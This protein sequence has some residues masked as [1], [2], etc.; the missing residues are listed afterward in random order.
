MAPAAAVP[1]VISLEGEA[2]LHPLTFKSYPAAGGLRLTY[3]APDPRDWDLGVLRARVGHREGKPNYQRMNTYRQWR[4]MLNQRCQN[5]GRS[6][7][8]PATGRVW[9]LLANESGDDAAEGWAS[10]PPICRACIPAA[11]AIC[12]HLR[13]H[14]ALYSVGGSEPFAVLAH[15]YRPGRDGRAVLDERNAMVRLDEFQRLT[16][17]L[18]LELRVLLWDAQRAPIP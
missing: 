8:D 6:A 18:A 15:L 7:V 12:P 4:C 17:A 1:Y 11:V 3:Q 10:A 13:E 2:V 16:R 9:W 14:A 5:C